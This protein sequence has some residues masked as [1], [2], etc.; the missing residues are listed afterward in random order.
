MNASICIILP[1]YN[2]ARYLARSINSVLDQS[3]EDWKLQIIDDASTDN[4]ETIVASYLSDSRIRYVRNP[5]R[6]GLVKTLSRS[7]ESVTCPYV[8][9]LDGDDYWIE[10]EKLRKQKEFLDSHP[11]YGLVGTYAAVV[12]EQ[13]EQCSSVRF[14]KTD[15]AIRRYFL[16]ENCFLHSSVLMRTDAARR[17]GGYR[18]SDTYGE[19]Y[20]LWLRIG[21]N[22]KLANLPIVATAYRKNSQGITGTG[23]REQVRKTRQIV[24]EHKHDY[25]FYSLGATLWSL[26]TIVPY[27]IKQSFSRLLI[28]GNNTL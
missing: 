26:R 7:L 25:P 12:N 21:K 9:R 17:V 22:Y 18:I 28:A 19:D 20:S 3:W 13:G 6:L 14:P 4:T 15:T 10:R 2:N 16:I 8:A 5:E 1:T 24:N 27:G 23:Y 11:D